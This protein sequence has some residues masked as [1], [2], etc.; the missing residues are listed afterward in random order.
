MEIWGRDLASGDT[1]L[2]KHNREFK[3]FTKIELRHVKHLEECLTQSNS[4][5]KAVVIIGL[6]QKNWIPLRKPG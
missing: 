2:P 4:I 3:G 5:D 6:S 1:E